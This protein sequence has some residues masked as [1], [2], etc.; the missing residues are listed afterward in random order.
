MIKIIKQTLVTQFVD[1]ETGEV[2]EDKR[3]FKDD[4]VKAD[5]KTT[6]SSSKKKSKNPC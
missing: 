3:E 4:S 1:E 2:F 6:A 5:K